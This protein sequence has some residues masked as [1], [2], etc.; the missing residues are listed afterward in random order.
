MQ[1]PLLLLP[2]FLPNKTQHQCLKVAKLLVSILK[3]LEHRCFYWWDDGDR[4][5]GVAVLLGVALRAVGG[6][7]CLWGLVGSFGGLMG[8]C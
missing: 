7:G 1:P 5:G 4:S 2:I 8:G 3:V 6:V